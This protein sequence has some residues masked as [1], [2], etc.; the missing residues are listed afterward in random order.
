MFPTAPFR[1]LA[2]QDIATDDDTFRI[3]RVYPDTLRRSIEEQGVK[4]PLLVV[5]H[6]GSLQLVSGWG[7]YRFAASD[8]PLP[9]YVLPTSTPIEELWDRHITDN[10][11]WNVVEAARVL[12][13]LRQLPTLD[14]QCI[15]RKK[16]P[17][18]GIRPAND[19]FQNYLRL[20]RLPQVA[21][22]FIERENL[23]L[24]RASLFAKLPATA[25]PTFF[26]HA[27][28]L[29]WTL[30]EVSE[31]LEL[32]AE[33]AEREQVSVDEILNAAC[34]GQDKSAALTYLRQR[35]FPELARY[36]KQLAGLMDDLNF[37]VPVRVEWDR[38]LEK[39]GIRLIAELDDADAL[40]ILC[41]EMESQHD[42]LK[43]FFDIL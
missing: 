19:L 25:L 26:V 15:V 10:D 18:L 3:R 42:R 23:P 7:R 21:H 22:D 40:Q 20:L 33:T 36:Q 1:W 28:N 8:A 35:R 17:L 9:A 37:S 43:R 30:N 2:H 24:R 41:R 39:P 13:R 5:E 16:L 32:V 14:D 34:T 38:R 31:V 4:T 6:N 29:R 27:D 11:R 12:E